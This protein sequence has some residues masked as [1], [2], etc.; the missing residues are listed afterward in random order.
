MHKPWSIKSPEEEIS[1]LLCNIMYSH[2]CSN[3]LSV[4]SI[5]II[6]SSI[7]NGDNENDLSFQLQ[8]F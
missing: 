3:N 6:V 5:P 2:D 1:S 8:K 7:V 4:F